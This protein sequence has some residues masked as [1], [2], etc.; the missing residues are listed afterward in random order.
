MDF[1]TLLDRARNTIS[2]DQLLRNQLLWMLL[3]RSI[4]YT[5]LLAISYFFKSSQFDIA[6]IPSNLLILLLL[7]VYLTTIISAFLL[8][9]LP[10]KSPK[11]WFYPDPH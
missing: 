9:D 1:A 8:N 6:V 7:I 2:T 4:L 5:L 3:L 11:F 10:G